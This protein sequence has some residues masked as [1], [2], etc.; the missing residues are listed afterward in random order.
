LDCT[1]IQWQHGRLLSSSVTFFVVKLT[2]TTVSQ[3]YHFE[4]LHENLPDH[5]PNSFDAKN[6]TVEASPLNNQPNNHRQ[7]SSAASVS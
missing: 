1:G 7:P 6:Y 5:F 4:I 2:F 3:E